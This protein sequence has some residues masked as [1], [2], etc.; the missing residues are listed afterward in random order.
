MTISE[1]ICV[2]MDINENIE[3]LLNQNKLLTAVQKEELNE[4]LVAYIN[5]LL[6]HDFNR[7]VQVLYKVDVSEQ[8]L[9]ELLQ[10]NPA[11]DAAVIITDLLI[12]RQEY[13]IKMKESFKPNDDIPDDEKW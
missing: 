12:E 5:H 10:K 11:I 9:K 13:K 7:L 6:V 2:R 1:D 4:K 8:K 3:L